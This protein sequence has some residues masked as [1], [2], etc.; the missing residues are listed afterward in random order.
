MVTPF[1]QPEIFDDGGLGNRNRHQGEMPSPPTGVTAAAGCPASAPDFAATFSSRGSDPF[2]SD[3]DKSVDHRATVAHFET[4]ENDS[5]DSSSFSSSPGKNYVTPDQSFFPSVSCSSSRPIR[6]NPG[7]N[8]SSPSRRAL[9]RPVPS[10]KTPPRAPA[11]SYTSFLRPRGL[12]GRV[13][14]APKGTGVVSVGVPSSDSSTGSSPTRQQRPFPVQQLSSSTAQSH[15]QTQPSQA[16]IH[17]S[18]FSERGRKR[19]AYSANGPFSSSLSNANACA[20]AGAGGAVTGVSSPNQPMC[21]KTPHP[22]SPGS[23]GL[24]GMSIHSPQR[25]GLLQQS[26][27]YINEAAAGAPPPPPPSFSPENDAHDN[28]NYLQ[29]HKATTLPPSD[30]SSMATFSASRRDSSNSSHDVLSG[31][32]TP[33]TMFQTPQTSPRRG[34][35]LCPSSALGSIGGSSVGG[36]SCF[37]PYRSRTP[38]PNPLMLLG[39]RPCHRRQGSGTSHVSAM[40]G[41]S[42]ALGPGASGSDSNPLDTSFDTSIGMSSAD[43]GGDGGRQHKEGEENGESF[44]SPSPLKVQSSPKHVPVMVLT[45]MTDAENNEDGGAIN[46]EVAGRPKPSSESRGLK[47][48]KDEESAA[49]LDRLLDVALPSGTAGVT[50]QSQTH[51]AQPTGTLLSTRAAASHPGPSP[52][53]S[54]RSFNLSPRKPLPASMMSPGGGST[55]SSMLERSPM[56]ETPACA[57]AAATKNYAIAKPSRRQRRN[58]SVHS[59]PG[60]FL[61]PRR[62]AEDGRLADLLFGE[63]D[64]PSPLLSSSRRG[65]GTTSKADSSKPPPFPSTT[66]FC[67]N[68]GDD[69]GAVMDGL[70]SGFNKGHSLSGKQRLE[71]SN[72]LAFSIGSSTNSLDRMKSDDGF[73]IKTLSFGGD[74]SGTSRYSVGTGTTPRRGSFHMSPPSSSQTTPRRNGASNGQSQT[75]SMQLPPGFMVRSVLTPSKSGG[76]L[77]KLM[78]AHRARSKGVSDLDD[79]SLSDSC[80]GSQGPTDMFFLNSPEEVAA[81]TIHAQVENNVADRYVDLFGRC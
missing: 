60:S 75:A 4:G 76:S 68:N 18:I 45:K 25:D 70:L 59:S 13:L 77:Q 32:N 80:D 8:G 30:S 28:T 62:T 22:M 9:T 58:A 33:T 35:N 57:V 67:A 69:M 34:G 78:D 38:S 27:N 47:S 12:Q 39:G 42:S 24:E 3:E 14:F 65:N 1:L 31:A 5:F 51:S 71:S 73:P 40:S 46:Q 16:R 81:A 37:G 64:P 26:N 20:G 63:D 7:S 55:G 48:Q 11:T 21:Q 23:I 49:D 19:R 61:S 15:Q 66:Q 72:S 10:G 36:G 56:I 2:A 54:V 17:T 74:Q 44:A 52:G 50:T 6:S 41:L 79:G 43:I 53:D 29:G